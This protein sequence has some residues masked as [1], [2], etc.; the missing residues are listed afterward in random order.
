MRAPSSRGIQR[1]RS[2]W[3]GSGDAVLFVGAESMQAPAS[4]RILR[5]SRQ[6][7]V[8][9]RRDGLPGEPGTA[10]SCWRFPS[11]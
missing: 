11:I 8:Q 4:A 1:H 10:M 5:V 6:K 7:R 2:D 9:Q 3:R